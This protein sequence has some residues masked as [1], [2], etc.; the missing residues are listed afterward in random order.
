MVEQ[1][2]DR[3]GCLAATK[4]Q[5]IEVHIDDPGTSLSAPPEW[6]DQLIAVL[7]GHRVEHDLSRGSSNP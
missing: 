1:A 6:I 4:G 2:A 5:Q 3:F 7:L